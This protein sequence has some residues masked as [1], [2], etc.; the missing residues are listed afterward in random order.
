[1]NL[2]KNQARRAAGTLVGAAAGDALGV[3]YEFASRLT[4]TEVP[5]MRGGGLGP[6]KPGEYSDD[7][8]MAVMIAE[9]IADGYDVRKRAGLD[10]VAENF[11]W[12]RQD[13]ASDIGS[14]TAGVL[15]DTR[16]VLTTSPRV[17]R[18]RYLPFTRPMGT[19]EV[20]VSASRQLHARTGRSAGNG[21]LMRT[22]PIALRY[23]TNRNACADAARKVA[24]L[25]HWDS[26]AG[27]SC[28]LW[29][30]AIRMSVLT[31]TSNLLSGLDL[32]PADRR[33]LWADRIDE[34]FT[35]S[36]ARFNPN[37]WTVTALQAAYSAVLAADEVPDYNPQS[38]FRQGLY[39][40]VRIGNDTD[41]V[42]AI[43]GA[44]LG[45]KS[46][47]NAIPGEW[48]GLVNGWPKHDGPSLDRLA[49]KI[50]SMA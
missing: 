16:T 7:T 2:D 46:G 28:V 45:A 18:W 21:A 31:G 17:T 27:D 30:E 47:V 26:D 34:V 13:G 20:M 40:A 1:M 8:Q 11:L 44:L 29:C 19:G 23:L 49:V 6:Y 41:T 9:A 12:W 33:T 50:A 36:P 24:Q 5:V 32:L 37:G 4:S 22:S 43:A 42:A 14:Q 35:S 39:A 48:A 38:A 10:K 3:P 15:F 25:T